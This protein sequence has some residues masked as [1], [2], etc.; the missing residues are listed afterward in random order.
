[1][2]SPFV[3]DSRVGSMSIKSLACYM[4]L[5][6]ILYHEVGYVDPILI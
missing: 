2:V 3:P 5:I 6:L 4:Q 1:M